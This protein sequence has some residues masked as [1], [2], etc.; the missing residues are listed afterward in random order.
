MSEKL[1]Q[2][3][4]PLTA[5]DPAEHTKRPN[6]PALLVRRS[7][8]GSK[9]PE[10][11]S[12]A[13]V[14][15]WEGGTCRQRLLSRAEDLLG[16]SVGRRRLTII[17]GLPLDLVQVLRDS[18]GVSPGFLEAHAGRRRYRPVT[19]DNGESFVSFEY[20]ELVKVHQ[21]AIGPDLGYKPSARQSDLVDVMDEAPFYS[22]SRDGQA[23]IF[24]H[25]SLWMGSKADIL[26]LDRPIWHDP[27]SQL[28]KA[29]RPLS[30][31]RSWQTKIDESQHDGTSVWNVL[32]A[33]GDELPGLED[34][35]LRTFRHTNVTRQTLPGLLCNAVYGKW[36]DFFETLPSHSQPESLQDAT[37]FWQA[38][39]SLEQ[40]LDVAHDPAPPIIHHP[41]WRRLLERLQ[42][43]VTISRLTTTAP[44]T[45]WLPSTQGLTTAQPQTRG[46]GMLDKTSRAYPVADRDW[47]GEK[48][49]DQ[50]A[51]DRVTYLGGILLPFSIVSAILSMNDEYSPNAPR[52]WVFWAAS[53]GAAI[54]CLFIIYL[55]RL[56]CLEV[57]FEI[58]AADTIES[59]FASGDGKARV[60]SSNGLG[61]ASML[62]SRL[63]L[64][65]R[66]NT[67]MLV[68]M[69]QPGVG[70]MEV[71]ADSAVNP[72]MIVQQCRDG[73]RPKAWQR[74][75]LGWGGAFKK[76]IGYY[77]WRGGMP[78]QFST[79]GPER[80]RMKMI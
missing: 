18:L 1:D 40:N 30:V 9:L 32:I 20:P 73:S 62:P 28:R 52:F 15:D 25:A 56:R 45:S 54:L 4:P 36:A 60:Y 59:I 31:A 75:E 19:Q 69:P 70:D 71:V 21:A 74:G 8:V 26:F 78:V 61:S 22:M 35:L 47:L 42:R 72:T 53:I 13:Y 7:S 58:S 37:L 44:Q 29:R 57:Y 48:E 16:E 34:S 6:R 76:V 14:L 77:R 33:E 5:N 17:Q 43:R 80:F 79:T 68:D 41:D 46:T 2:Q 24:C 55:D 3:S 49:M 66:W 27:S 67:E 10:T 65:S 64:P 39:E 23:V 12:S 50:R 51:L 11:G 38:T 63:R